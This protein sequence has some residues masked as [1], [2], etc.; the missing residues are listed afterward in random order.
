M[1]IRRYLMS[2]VGSLTLALSGL[3]C[4]DHSVHDDHVDANVTYAAAYVVNGYSNTISVIRLADNVESA[5]ISLHGAQYPH[6]IAYDSVHNRLAV[7]ITGTDLSGGHEHGQVA[8]PGLKIMVL[9]ATSGRIEKEIACDRMPHNA[10]FMRSGAELWFGQSDTARS[11]VRVYSTSDWTLRHTIPVG[12]GLSE[13][14]V[15]ADG[16]FV[17]AANTGDASISAIDPTTYAVVATIPVGLTPVGAWPASNGRMYVDNE[18]GRSISEIDVDSLRVVSTIDCGFTPAYALYLPSG[19][20]WVSD[21]D[22]GRIVYYRKSS[23]TW[24]EAGSVI[25]GAKAHAMASSKD[26][27][28]VYVTNQGA[29]T[30]SVINATTHS[31]V[32]TVRVGSL[33]N[34]IVL[35]Q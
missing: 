32:A 15:A 19:E 29:G 34:G 24:S 8:V 14:S 26:A 3:S 22:G 28:T 2:L 4:S 35:R 11:E 30:V 9:D 1:K 33:P 25:T 16:S 20:L 21:V 23:G 12:A 18:R 17:F 13:V 27:T 6:H 10:V 7:A 5:V 31:I